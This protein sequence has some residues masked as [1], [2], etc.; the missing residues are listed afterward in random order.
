MIYKHA[1]TGQFAYVED[2]AGLLEPA[3]RL[4][5]DVTLFERVEH[6]EA[7]WQDM[8]DG[9]AKAKASLPALKPKTGGRRG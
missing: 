2:V 4:G 3:I 7:E 8:L 6:A 1:V 5:V 9:K